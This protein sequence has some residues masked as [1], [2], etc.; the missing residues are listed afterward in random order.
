MANAETAENP[1]VIVVGGG[2]AGLTAAHRLLQRGYDVTLIEANDFLGGKLAAHRRRD[3]AA[4]KEKC[5]VCEDQGGCLQRGD[6]HEHCYHMYLNWYHNFWELMEEFGVLDKLVAQP[7]IY[8]IHRRDIGEPV[9][10]AIPF[11]NMG[12]PWTT[13]RN[14]FA[15][16]VG[17]ADMMLLGQT[18]ADLAGE[19]ERRDSW[20]ERTSITAFM[21]SRAYTTDQAL[22]TTMRTTAQAFASPSYLSSAR[23]Y[24][25]LLN[26]GMRLPEPSMWL[27]TAN[28]Q[29]AIFMPWLMRLARVANCVEV[30]NESGD[31]LKEEPF[32]ALRTHV[33]PKGNRNGKLTIKMLASLK[34]LCI[35]KNTGLIVKIQL[36]QNQTSPTVQ[37]SGAPVNAEKPTEWMDVKGDLILAVPLDVL[38]RLATPEIVRWAPNLPDVRYL[39]TEPMIS[40]DLFFKKRLSGL[41]NGI[42]VLLDSP[43]E[44]S[45]FDN[46]Q[47]WKDLTDGHTVLNVVASNADTLV[48][49]KPDILTADIEEHIKSTLKK[50]LQRYI[51]FNDDDL[52]ECRTYMQTNIGEQLFV[53]QV[54]SWQW[55]P[56]TTCGISNLFIAG[57]YCQTFIDVVTIEGATVSGL[58]AAEALRRRRGKGR[59]IRILQPDQY[60]VLA[61]AALAASTRPVAYLARAVSSV[62]YAVK[63]RYRQWFPN[64]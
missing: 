9:S 63:S 51:D 64:G 42:T 18:Q 36:E 3:D 11:A 34:S 50:E 7:A 40:M 29:R 30:L 13:L 27:L 35:D 26:Y 10:P 60:P 53:N 32:D 23:S 24:K 5:S 49:S 19:P 15:G 43:H 58:M 20:L 14:I 28:S 44:M 55:R 47:T 21:K 48:P 4:S 57:D 54:G 33:S 39:R 1:N 62:D 37:N 16:L 46:S 56:Q 8:N 6:W 59:P 31:F 38:G 17:P 12:S 25:G 22:A 45:F 41:P 2:V 61:V 52:F